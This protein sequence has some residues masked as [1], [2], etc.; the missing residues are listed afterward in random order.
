ML[1]ATILEPAEPTPM[2]TD[3]VKNSQLVI[4]VNKNPLDPQQ[5]QLT[6]PNVSLI[7][8]TNASSSITSTPS[9]SVTSI[10]APKTRILPRNLITQVSSGLTVSNS[11]LIKVRKYVQHVLISVWY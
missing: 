8:S 9:L 10:P 1:G 7:L 11:E 3:N 6:L 5:V 2:V 4:Q